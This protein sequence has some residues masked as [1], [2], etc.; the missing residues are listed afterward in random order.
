[1]APCKLAKCSLLMLTFL[2]AIIVLAVPASREVLDTSSQSTLQILGTSSDDFGITQYPPTTTVNIPLTSTEGVY[3][4]VDMS[5]RAD[6]LI[7][8]TGRQYCS[9]KRR[10]IISTAFSDAVP[11]PTSDSIHKRFLQWLCIT[12]AKFYSTRSFESVVCEAFQL[13][14]TSE[15][16]IRSLGTSPSDFLDPSSTR[17]DHE[18]RGNGYIQ[19]CGH[20]CTARIDYLQG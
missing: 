9:R 7:R 17:P 4:F 10:S 16:C 1:M 14:E 15:I 19:T 5:S 18:G 3:L 20:W 8:G 13:L 6:S 2:Q 12:R 11:N